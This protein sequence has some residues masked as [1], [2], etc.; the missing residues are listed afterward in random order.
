MEAPLWSLFFCIKNYLYRVRYLKIHLMFKYLI[1]IIIIMISACLPEYDNPIDPEGDAPLAPRATL[2][3]VSLIP[4]QNSN[5]YHGEFDFSWENTTALLLEVS[6][7]QG[8]FQ[9]VDTIAAPQKEFNYSVDL[10]DTSNYQFRLS[11]YNE[12]GLGLRSNIIAD[13]NLDTADI[14]PPIL[15]YQSED[16]VLDQE[17]IAK[18]SHIQLSIQHW[19][20]S[21]IQS[22]KMNGE[23]IAENLANTGETEIDLNLT[24]FKNT[25]VFEIIDQSI[26]SRKTVDT[27]TIVRDNDNPPAFIDII[28]ETI[29]WKQDSSIDF[30]SWHVWTNTTPI[31]TSTT[32]DY[33]GTDTSYQLTL[34][35]EMYILVMLEDSL[36]N[37][38]TNPYSSI[39]IREGN[40][41]RGDQVLIPAGEVIDLNHNTITIQKDFWMDTIEVKQSV[42]EFYTNFN[43]SVYQDPERPVESISFLD[44]IQ[45]ANSKSKF[46]QL[47]TVYQYSSVSG[48]SINDLIIRDVQG[49]RLPYEDEWE[50][51]AR[52][53][54]DSVA[55]SWGSDLG[56]FEVYNKLWFNQNAGSLRDTL[57][58]ASS[59]G[60]QK[61]AQTLPNGFGLYDMQGNVDEWTNNF[62]QNE[63]GR[64]ANRSDD[65][66]PQDCSDECI[67]SESNILSEEFQRS[68]R[69]GYWDASL[70]NST[71]S[72]RRARAQSARTRDIGMRLMISKGL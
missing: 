66:G 2:L 40:T 59:P 23:L 29:I 48:T 36:G 50:L 67:W 39:Q 14:L 24:Q 72:S 20:E 58:F 16:L 41:Y 45:Y 32:P 54:L 63:A 69:G 19:D 31:D 38:I 8:E 43:P 15:S 55:N 33:S 56:Y 17:W 4:Y 71:L 44:A 27:L 12:S 22:I 70:S 61:V 10:S 34:S 60:P 35:S 25:F 26:S 3:K 9:T 42:F 51:A 21:Q 18:D 37:R 47:D 28:D 64:A 49:F 57:P 62:W 1:I 6:Q 7:D 52:A 11:S 5:V 65:T 13:F 53:G 68:V 30:K 46:Y